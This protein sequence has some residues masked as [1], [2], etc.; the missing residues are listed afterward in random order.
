MLIVLQKLVLTPAELEAWGWRIPFA[1]GALLSVI[2]Y[3]MRRDLAETEAF[4]QAT[5]REGSITALL[6]H[7][8]EVAIVVGLTLGGT[9]AFYTYTTYM[10]KF[11][12]NTAGFS[13]DTA[14]LIS[15]SAPCSST[16]CCSRLSAPCPMWSA[17][18]LY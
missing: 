7:P 13:K 3:L 14:T 11:L 16:C 6:A 4:E 15:A 18:G 12:V 9:V 17:G 10:Q 1:I 8:R 2:A 5:R